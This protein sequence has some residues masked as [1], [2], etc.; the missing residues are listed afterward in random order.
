[1]APDTDIARCLQ[2][3]R[4]EPANA[5][6]R[7]RFIALTGEVAV[8]KYDPVLAAAL[9]DCLA[10]PGV[11]CAWADV[12]WCATLFHD[13]GFAPLLALVVTKRP[14]WL[15]GN[16][17]NAVTDFSPL[18]TPYFLLG[19]QKIVP[20][21]LEFE[22]F[23]TRLR[24]FLLFNAQ[25]LEEGPFLALS[26]A[27]AMYAFNTGYILECT[28]KESKK[29]ESLKGRTDEKSVA[30]LACYLPLHRLGGAEAIPGLFAQ[31]VAGPRALAE[32][33]AAVG[34]LTSVD[35]GVSLKVK[36]M[37][38]ESP[39]PLWR[40][41]HEAEFRHWPPD[42]AVL[43]KPGAKALVAGCG[44]GRESAQLAALYP[45]A[46]ILA[47][48]ITRA[49]LAYAMSKAEEYGLKNVSYRQADILKL[50][51]VLKPE[52]D[53]IHCVGVLHH[54]LDPVAG[55]RSLVNLLK[56]GG[57]MHIG[58]YGE[59]PRRA[60]VAARAAIAKGGYAATEEG[61]RAFRRDSGKLLAP[62]HL[63]TLKKALDYYYLPMYRDL[64]FH[65][66][67]NRFTIPQIRAALDELGLS[68]KGFKLPPEVFAA[69]KG[70]PLDLGAW[71]TFER[72]HPDTFIHSYKFWC[73]K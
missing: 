31:Q 38:E 62:E 23:V 42:A 2:D 7:R 11:D 26:T 36:E 43:E 10:T 50:S 12:T 34:A 61:M 64:L 46:E 55:W 5:N 45:Q 57:T 9:A 33:A 4:A 56:P 65:V 21:S 68:F 37:Y 52:S 49:S 58:L 53:Y 48:D 69:F 67:E 73:T 66:H 19:L 15:P 59:V 28:K 13:P 32:K 14:W 3:M 16:P 47:V 60:V 41:L 6:H 54:M 1:M 44:T 63:A 51:T 30:L 22:T 27:V 18:L 25:D 39:Y 40:E 70:D 8:T 17:F 20:P 71:E 24:A 35:D 29:I 72:A